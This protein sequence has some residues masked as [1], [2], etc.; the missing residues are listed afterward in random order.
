MRM[1]STV[2]DFYKNTGEALFIDKISA[3]LGI[4]T[5]RMRIVNVRAGSVIVDFYVDSASKSDSITEI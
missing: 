4:E 2:E 3:F 5:S 1:E